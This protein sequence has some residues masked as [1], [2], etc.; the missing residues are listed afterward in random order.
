MHIYVHIVN[1]QCECLHD[2][3]HTC[4]KDSSIFTSQKHIITNT[5]WHSEI[6]DV[7]KKTKKLHYDYTN[8][9]AKLEFDTEKFKSMDITYQN[10]TNNVF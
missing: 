5:I 4:T 3:N 8:C 6:F 1:T 2:V 7:L 9:N 10:L